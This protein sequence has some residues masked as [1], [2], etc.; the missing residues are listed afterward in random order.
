MTEAIFGLV[1]VIIGGL[2]NG[3]VSLL[4]DKKSQKGAGKVA[5]RMLL[6]EI[7]NN[8]IATK[9]SLEKST[10]RHLRL[11]LSI[12]EWTRRREPLAAVLSDT[13]WEAVDDYYSLA[14]LLAQMREL[15]EANDDLG[16]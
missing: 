3:G 12:E 15:V 9:L 10:W 11:A 4:V 14:S 6:S 2:L 13:E 1:G 16:D 5:A 7:T 8:E